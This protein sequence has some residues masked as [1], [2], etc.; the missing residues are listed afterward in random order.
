MLNKVYVE[1]RDV[2]KRAEY[3]VLSSPPVVFKVDQSC[4]ELDLLISRYGAG[5]AAFITACNPKGAHQSEAKNL[6]AMNELK[7][8]IDDLQLPYLPGVGRD[9]LG[10]WKEDS[11]LILGINQDQACR[12][13]SLFEQNAIV[14]LVMG[15]QPELVWLS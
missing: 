5:C 7:L 14:M 15:K 2:Y 6:L 9:P 3:L 8:A 4:P 13:G 12:L 1:F 10:E 11:Y